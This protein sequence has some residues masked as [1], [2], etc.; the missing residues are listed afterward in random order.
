M[1]RNPE[2]ADNTEVLLAEK[3]MHI[4]TRVCTVHVPSSVSSL[5]L[6]IYIGI[7]IDIQTYGLYMCLF[8]YTYMY[9]NINTY[10]HTYIHTY[11]PTYLHTYI[12]TDRPTYI[13]KYSHTP[14]GHQLLVRFL[15]PTVAAESVDI[16]SVRPEDTSKNL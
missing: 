8:T 6:S 9:I 13:H 3:A 14:P 15:Q 5:S 12:H 7:H 16:G 2:H 11:L 4:P 10:L 1:N